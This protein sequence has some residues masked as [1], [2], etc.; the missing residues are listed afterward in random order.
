MDM[1]HRVQ[2]TEEDRL[3]QR[4]FWREHHEEE[5]QELEMVVLSF[6]TTCSPTLA[7]YVKNLNA[8]RFAKERPAAVEAIIEDHYVDDGLMSA[9]TEEELLQLVLEIRD[10]HAA[11][12]FSMHKFVSKS[13][14]VLTGLG[15][16]ECDQK[17]VSLSNT[18]ILGLLRDTSNDYLSFRFS[19][20]RFRTELMDGTDAPTKR[21]MLSVAMCIFDPLGLVSYL[22]VEAKIILRE[23]CRCAAGW[24][25]KLHEGIQ[26]RWANWTSSLVKLGD[27]SVPRWHGTINEEVD[28]HVFV[29]ASENAICAVCYVVQRA[30]SGDSV[31]SLCFAKCLVAPV[32][33]KSI[34]RL[35]L[36][37]AVL[38]IRVLKIVLKANA[39]RVR[40]TNFW[41][42]QETCCIG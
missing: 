9:E 17:K 23:A 11:G 19:R 10:I 7:Q 39:W 14:A 29:D 28:L 37:V 35:E 21:E 22:C 34:P 15:V 20:Q 4:F 24:D 32:R 42:T 25:D 3:T 38:G 13:Q 30:P 27:V 6:G 8:E 41:K 26:Q 18:A 33:A 40:S 36:D 16:A 2:L 31:R 1:F 5:L 12:G